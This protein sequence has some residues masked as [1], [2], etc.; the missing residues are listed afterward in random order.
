MKVRKDYQLF[1]HIKQLIKK[2][3]HNRIILLTHKHAL[4]ACLTNYRKRKSL[5][6]SLVIELWLIMFQFPLSYVFL[7]KVI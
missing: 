1:N 2:K 4:S 6:I 7:D 3:N 5:G